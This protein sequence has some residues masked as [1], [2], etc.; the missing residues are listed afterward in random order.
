MKEVHPVCFFFFLFCFPFSVFS[1]FC[2][3]DPITTAAAARSH[4][5]PRFLRGSRLP[6]GSGGSSFPSQTLRRNRCEGPPLNY[7]SIEL[8]NQPIIQLPNHPI[9]QI[10]IIP[11]I[12]VIQIIQITNYPNFQLSN[13][14]STQLSS[15]G[16]LSR[17]DGFP[18]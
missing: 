4:F 12:Q 15:E 18:C 17:E 13:Y 8:S 11:I 1:V 9:I 14:P 10:Q 3:C 5:Q 6:G 16:F 2:F 7:P